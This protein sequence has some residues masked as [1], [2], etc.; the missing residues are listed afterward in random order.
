MTPVYLSTYLL[1][2]F[3][4]PGKR[5]QSVS[6]SCFQGL[7]APIYKHKT[8]LEISLVGGKKKKAMEAKWWIIQIGFGTNV[9][10]FETKM[11]IIVTIL[12]G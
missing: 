5:S 10:V 8:S 1:I 11:K 3:M 4:C 2:T 7:L 12:S 6:L 9:S